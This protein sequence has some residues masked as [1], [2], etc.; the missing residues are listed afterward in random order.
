MKSVEWLMLA[1]CISSCL[2]AGFL[3]SLAMDMEWYSVLIKSPLTPPSWVFGAAWTVLYVLMGVSLFLVISNRD[4]PI[5]M[6]AMILFATQ[7]LL[8]IAWSFIFFSHHEVKF[9]VLEM[10]ILFFVV[11]AMVIVFAKISKIS[12]ILQIPYIL[13]LIF[14]THLAYYILK[15]NDFA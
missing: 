4:T 6:L 2:A 3:G 8:N 5:F 9:A 12:A 11:V 1:A 14:A 7:F 10:I 13:W 15:N